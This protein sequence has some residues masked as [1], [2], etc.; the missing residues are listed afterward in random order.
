MATPLELLHT[1]AQF[2]LEITRG[3]SFLLEITLRDR[4]TG[5]PV[6]LAGLSGSAILRPSVDTGTAVSIDVDVD[7]STTG[8]TVGLIVLSAPGEETN[9]YPQNGVWNLAVTDGSP[10]RVLRKTVLQGRFTLIRDVVT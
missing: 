2:D 5:I 7:Q 3:D 1:P 6:S 10:G 9:L 8:E 4:D